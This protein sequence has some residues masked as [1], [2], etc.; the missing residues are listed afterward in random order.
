MLVASALCVFTRFSFYNFCQ[1]TGIF[2]LLIVEFPT[3]VSDSSI[4]QFFCRPTL[5]RLEHKQCAVCLLA[6]LFP[7]CV[8]FRG[9]AAAEADTLLF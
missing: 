2:I 4:A 3:A 6:L 7:L 1:Q 9:R 5:P 8:F